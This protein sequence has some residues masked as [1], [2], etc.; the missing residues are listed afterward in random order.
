LIAYV[1]LVILAMKQM[2]TRR[3]RFLLKE[4]HA[5][6]KDAGSFA[7]HNHAIAFII[8]VTLLVTVQFDNTAS[9]PVNF[10]SVMIWLCVA[11][12]GAIKGPRGGI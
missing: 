5:P 7:H 10:V 9:L 11:L 12:A 2:P 8:A 3:E 4:I 6:P 1:L